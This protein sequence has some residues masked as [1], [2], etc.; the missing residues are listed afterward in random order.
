MS[1]PRPLSS[2]ALRALADG[3]ARV[4]RKHPVEDVVRF[5]FDVIDRR[6]GADRPDH[7]A[8]P[9]EPPSPPPAPV[10]A[11]DGRRR[12]PRLAMARSWLADLLADGPVAASEIARAADE[13]GYRD[14]LV[15][16]ARRDLGA[17]TRREGA[18]WVWRLPTPDPAPPAPDDDG[19]DG[20]A[21]LDLHGAEERLSAIDARAGRDLPSRAPSCSCER[22]VIDGETCARCGR[23][24][25]G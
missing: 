11:A 8:A 9:P 19:D 25:R 17:I 7:A 6:L 1:T 12:A 24:A 3:V 20:L 16:Q 4:L 5:A 22:P 21:D 13:A 15:S 23:R 14:K 10:A 2:P 18:A